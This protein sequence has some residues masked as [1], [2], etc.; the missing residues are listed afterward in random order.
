MLSA[1]FHNLIRNM[2][3]IAENV[4]IKYIDIP[5]YRNR[6]IFTCKGDFAS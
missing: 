3:N 6:L 5:E 1:D 4:D 2:S